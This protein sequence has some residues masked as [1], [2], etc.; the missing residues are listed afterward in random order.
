MMNASPFRSHLMQTFVANARTQSRPPIA[1]FSFGKANASDDRGQQTPGYR[2]VSHQPHDA[3]INNYR[4]PPTLSTTRPIRLQQR[5]SSSVTS[6]SLDDADPSAAADGSPTDTAPASH[7]HLSP[8][9][10]KFQQF[11]VRGIG[12]Q[13]L[14][15]VMQF[16]SFGF[17][18][19]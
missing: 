3:S 10:Q 17:D 19:L 1:L 7:P 16:P 18:W 6:T 8:P 4:S 12:K 2:S 9:A 14:P 15:S 5:P 11:I 13:K